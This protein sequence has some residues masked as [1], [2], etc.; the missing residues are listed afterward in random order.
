MLRNATKRLLTGAALTGA[1]LWI[2]SRNRERSRTFYSPEE[3]ERFCTSLRYFDPTQLD[4]A[5]RL[6]FNWLCDVPLVVEFDSSTR[7]C[8]VH[9]RIGYKVYTRISAQELEQI[10]TRPDDPLVLASREHHTRDS[11]ERWCEA[12]RSDQET[13]T[14]RADQST[15]AKRQVER[16]RERTKDERHVKI[17]MLYRERWTP[18]YWLTLCKWE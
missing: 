2:W 9:R 10:G 6:R 16:I 3:F 15:F 14:A 11:W 17:T 13:A 18:L 4:E 12:V 1:S 8:A 7:E 5:G